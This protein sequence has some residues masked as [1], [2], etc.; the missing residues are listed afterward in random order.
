MTETAFDDPARRERLLA[1]LPAADQQFATL[2]AQKQIPGAV[3]GVILDGELVHTYA[4]GLRDVAA[5]APVMADS[6]F[7]IASMSKSFVTMALLMLRDQGLLRLDESVVRY[8]PEVLSWRAPTADCAPLT[9]RH[10]ISMSAGLPEDNPWGDRLLAISDEDFSTLLAAG[11]TFANAPGVAY[12]YSNLGYMLLGRV[13]S[14]V[15]GI[16]M[17]DFVMQQILRP[18]GMLATGWQPAQVPAE[19]WVHGYDRQGDA[20]VLEPAL[21]HGGDAAGFAGLC[22]NIPDLA[23]YVSS[24]LAA[25]PPRD[26]EERLPLRRSSLREMQQIWRSAGTMMVAGAVDRVYAAGYGGGLFVA[27]DGEH[28]IVSHSGGLPGYGSVMQ[29]LPQQGLGIVALGNLTYARMGEI[30]TRLRTA[31]LAE[32][33]LPR[34]VVRPAPALTAAAAAVTD[35]VLH[36]DDAL[37][38]RLFADNFFLD[39]SRDRWRTE[40][41]G[42]AA[43]HGLLSATGAL[44][45]ENPLRGKWRLNGERGWCTLWISLTPTSP[46]LVQALE[47]VSV[48]PPEPAL[49][50]AIDALALLLSKPT[51]RGVDRLFAASSDRVDLHRRLQI[52]H[53]Q[54]GAC[55]VGE[56]VAGNG[57]TQATMR[58]HGSR[59]DLT[60][61]VQMDA[62]SGKLTGAEFKSV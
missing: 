22:T 61:V 44:N 20:W 30:A 62:A 26:E 29:W 41:A 15:A 3:Y 56:S 2:A 37:A 5:K 52:A 43:R 53:L 28:S 31:M 59:S 9:L 6:I 21:A 46:P 54:H 35:L 48:L 14:K 57:A 27:D 1:A 38:D 19:Q 32:A 55:G 45:V 17:A 4:V 16:A 23:R 13:V 51:R 40:V 33:R 8:V 50:R 34:R 42:L 49:Q 7:R 25:W 47:I 12:E 11:A 24:F 58:F 10:L 60:V 18:L 39:Q 36:W